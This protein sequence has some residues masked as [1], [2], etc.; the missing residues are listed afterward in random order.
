M[1]ISVLIS[2]Y[3]KGNYLEECINSCLK[4]THE[5]IEII[6]LDNYSD[7]NTKKILEK[8]ENKIKIY[9]KN[10]ISNFPA[11][12]QIDL[13]KEGIKY[14]NGEI[15]CLLDADDFFLDNKIYKINK[16]FEKNNVDI[17]Y[18]LPKIK[19]KDKYKNFKLKK[20]FQK[21]IWPTII[22]TSAISLKKNYLINCINL[23]L[24]EDFSLLEV[25]FRLNA[26]SRCMD[27]NF[28]ILSKS[29]SIYRIVSNS[30]MAN[31]KKYSKKWWFR[32]SQAHN[33]MKKIYALNNKVYSNY[34]DIKLTNFII[35][36]YN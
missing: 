29:L 24:F 22:N 14:C 30:I 2:S 27:N 11:L 4:Q 1:K 19:S 7:D 5:N 21:N 17:V 31:S 9:F 12:N 33:F 10:K 18:D 15:I 32:R 34:F 25:D 8:Y 26:I 23:N 6:L 13:I 36:F 28:I 16:I 20:K 35:K 3:N